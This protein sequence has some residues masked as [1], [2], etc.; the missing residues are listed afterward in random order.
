MKIIEVVAKR[1][2]SRKW[3]TASITMLLAGTLMFFSFKTFLN[4]LSFILFLCA[5]YII[6]KA[7]RWYQDA[8]KYFRDEGEE[9]G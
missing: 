9:L 4:V 7:I 5:M 2:A 8:F 3:F 6:Y 1:V